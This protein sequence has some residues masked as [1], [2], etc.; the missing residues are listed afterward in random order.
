MVA[1]LDMDV[2]HRRPPEGVI[3]H[4]DRGIQ[5]TSEAFR[6]RQQLSKEKSLLLFIDKMNYFVQ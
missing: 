2:K 3:L 1:A 6:K 5:H 4:S